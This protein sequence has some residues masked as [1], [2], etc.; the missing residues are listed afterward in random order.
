MGIAVSGNN[1]RWD[2]PARKVV[3]NESVPDVWREF[4]ESS[5]IWAAR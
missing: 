5:S 2:Y 1:T 3:D 4:I